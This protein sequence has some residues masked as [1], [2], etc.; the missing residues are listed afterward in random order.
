MLHPGELRVAALVE[1]GAK[2]VEKDAP[3]A[4]VA[5]RARRRVEDALQRALAVRGRDD[6]QSLRDAGYDAVL[7]GESLVTATNPTESLQLLRC[8]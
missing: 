5:A 3:A 2:I 7:V 4:G 6:A 8:T 1:P